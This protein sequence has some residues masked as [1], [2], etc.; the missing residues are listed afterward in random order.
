MHR[1][2]MDTYLR[3]YGAE[4]TAVLPNQTMPGEHASSPPAAPAPPEFLHYGGKLIPNVA[5]PISGMPDVDPRYQSQEE[6]DRAVA[7]GQQGRLSRLGESV[8][9]APKAAL[10]HV[11]RRGIEAHRAGI[12]L[13][14]SGVSDLAANRL[15]PTVPLTDMRQSSGGGILKTL[16]GAAM[17]GFAPVLG[18]QTSIVIPHDRKLSSR[19]FD[20]VPYEEMLRSAQAG[21]GTATRYLRNVLTSD[22]GLLDN[23]E[24][25]RLIRN[26]ARDRLAR[27]VEWARQTGDLPGEANMNAL[28]RLAEGGPR[29]LFRALDRKEFLPALFLAL[30]IP[31]LGQANPPPD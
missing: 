1:T 4:P 25:D 27:D 18:A 8:A 5:P 11:L 3:P 10:E 21:D 26:V 16:A 14:K 6:F 19:E 7:H 28:R 9:E 20:A 12:E 24:F 30:G 13:M 31:A 15:V 17:Y 22:P 2:W 23:P 29:G